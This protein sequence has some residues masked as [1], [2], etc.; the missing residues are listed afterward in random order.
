MPEHCTVEAAMEVV[1]GKWK[2]AILKHLTAGPHRFGELRRELPSITQRM[3]TRQLREL[4][5]DGIVHREVYPQ[6]PPKVEYSLTE[7]GRT[8]ED[9]IQRLEE[10]GA[11]YR[12]QGLPKAADRDAG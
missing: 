2:M 12:A 7:I 1:G 11:W 8:L 10:W 4:E 6:V 9:V 5:A 3:L